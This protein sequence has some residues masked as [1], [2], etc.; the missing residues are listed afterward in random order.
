MSHIKIKIDSVKPLQSFNFRAKNSKKK[1]KSW[2]LNIFKG[3]GPIWGPKVSA[4]I[5]R[6]FDDDF[7]KTELR[8]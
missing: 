4:M 3:I 2:F 8:S 1:S 7:Q 6:I 5:V